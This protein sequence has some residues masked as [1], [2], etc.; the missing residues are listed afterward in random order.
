[1]VGYHVV[2]SQT[3]N[4][5]K[6]SQGNRLQSHLSSPLFLL[7]RLKKG[8]VCIVCICVGVWD[9]AYSAI[10][11]EKRMP[12]TS[13]WNQEFVSHQTQAWEPNCSPLQEQYGHLTLSH[14]S[15]PHKWF[16]NCSLRKTKSQQPI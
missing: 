11:G 14:L 1:M 10:R 13:D 16:Q 15:S 8:I 4:L 5:W 3:Q 12:E 7:L 6:S 2:G 9:F